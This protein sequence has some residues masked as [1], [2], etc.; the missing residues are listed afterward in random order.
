MATT[1]FGLP[2]TEILKH[3]W[4]GAIGVT[5]LGD[6]LILDDYLFIPVADQKSDHVDHRQYV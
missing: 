6:A 4:Y 1:N 2:I 3:V 5:L